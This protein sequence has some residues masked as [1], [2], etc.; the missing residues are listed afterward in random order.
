MDATFIQKARQ[1]TPGCQ[2]VLHFNNAGAALIPQPVL[3][4]V[5][6]HQQLEAERGGYEAAA[7]AEAKIE[8]FYPLAAK[9][10]NAAP[11][12]IAFIENATR[13]WDMAF[14][15]LKFK[16]GDRILTAEA[17]YASNYIAFLQVAKKTGAE[18]V[19]VP[20]DEYGQLSLRHLENLI[21]VKTKLIAITHIPTQGG[22]INPAEEVGKIANQAGVFYLLDATQSIGQMPID[23]KKIGCH[24]LCATGRK[25]LRGPRGT[26]FL[27]V[28]QSHI[29]HMEPPFLDLLAATW[30][31]KHAY[32]IRSDAKRFE[33]WETNY[34]N[35]LG[36]AAA[37]DYAMQW[38]LDVVW[39]RIQELATTLRSQLSAIP[40]VVLQDLGLHKCGIVTFS[41]KGRDPQNICLLL[42]KRNINVSVS[43]QE[44][45]R[46][47][48]E[49]RGLPSIV[50]S[51][52]HYYNT[53]EEIARFCQEIE[54]F[55][56]APEKR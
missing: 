47:D 38:G 30:T 46:L 20:N 26:G 14:Y 12:E 18:V 13:A 23:V 4:A 7:L 22:L 36:L 28:D 48:L 9:L 24:A 17:E 39:Q 34:A 2:H 37:M 41:I 6:D 55:I 8:A 16:P 27:Y 43:L 50:R 44:Y 3:K 1:E 29:E 51:S 31:E 35:K 49:K 53:K 21:D 5:A 54:A 19:V 32:K 33:T 52:V 40:G 25:F 10:I 42:R 15:S 56:L 11:A 45:A